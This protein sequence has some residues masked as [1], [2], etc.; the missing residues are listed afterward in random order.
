MHKYTSYDL[1]PEQKSTNLT[2]FQTKFPQ[3]LSC[4]L[5]ISLFIFKGP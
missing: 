5:K 2:H 4:M 1:I 3:N